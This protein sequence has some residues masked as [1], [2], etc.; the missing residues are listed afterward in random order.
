MV[1]HPA[2]KLRHIRAF[3]DIA[4]EGSLSAVAMRQGITQPGLS[5]SLSELEAL[6]GVQL[7]LREKRRLVLTEEGALFRRHAAQALQMLELGA[8]TLQ[9][10]T[11][12]GAIRIGILPS[13]A[14]TLFPKVALRF[15]AF[16][17]ETVLKIETGP[18]FHLLRMLREGGIDL[19]VGRMPAAADMAGLSFEHLYEEPITLVVRR[20]HPGIGQPIP[21]LLQRVPVILPPETALIRR[22]VDEYLLSLGISGLRPA[23]ETVAL[24]VGRGMVVNSDAAWFISRG[25]VDEELK[26]GDLVEVPTG[27]RFLSGAVGITRRQSAITAAGLGILVEFFRSESAAFHPAR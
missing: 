16:A 18:H 7:F 5:R 1:M 22:A 26:R 12:S 24:A 14:T 20:G 10:G 25:V 4:S 27:A 23:V 19:M 3:L 15:R 2:I 13:A 21:V 11:G 6:L 8:A 9:P 17:P